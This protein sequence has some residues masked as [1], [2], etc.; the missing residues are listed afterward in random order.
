MRYLLIVLLGSTIFFSCKKSDGNSAP[1]VKFKS[2]TEALYSGAAADSILPILTIEVSDDDGDLG[3]NEG[4]DTSYIFIKNL[5]VAPFKMDSFKF[6]S[7]LS[8]LPK[9][10]FKTYQNVDI[11]LNGNKVLGGG[12]SLAYPSSILTNRPR[13]DSA[14]YEVYVKDFAKNKSEVIRTDKPLVFVTR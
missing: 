12:R 7:S 6:P 3:F 13:R 8:Q 2:I 5:T 4:K 1:K 14:F 10:T 9:S 11:D